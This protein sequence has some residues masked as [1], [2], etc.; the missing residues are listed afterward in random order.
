M[1]CSADQGPPISS[2]GLRHRSRVSTATTRP[3][4][5]L[6]LIAAA[7]SLGCGASPGPTRP[8]PPARTAITHRAAEGWTSD[9]AGRFAS[10]LIAAVADLLAGRPPGP[11]DFRLASSTAR[12]GSETWLAGAPSPSSVAGLRLPAVLVRLDVRAAREAEPPTDR[13]LTRLGHGAEGGRRLGLLITR[14]GPRVVQAEALAAA[15]LVPDPAWRCGGPLRAILA[16][17]ADPHGHPWQPLDLAERRTIGEGLA[18]RLA[19]FP[20]GLP[21]SADLGAESNAGAVR[22]AGLATDGEDGLQV[23]L[24]DVAVLAQ[25]AAGR[26]YLLGLTLAAAAPPPCRA[27]EAPPPPVGVPTADG[28]RPLVFVLSGPPLITFH[29]LSETGVAATDP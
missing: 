4:R 23:R 10:G 12:R 27:A 19:I 2:R 13:E 11:G 5:A 17:L 29:P 14:A 16:D 15:G 20:R 18:T 1:T 28:D 22:G 25:D 24:V 26:R 7:V 3:L 6:L 8:T 9:A 21:S